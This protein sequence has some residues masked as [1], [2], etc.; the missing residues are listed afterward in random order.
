M[1]PNTVLPMFV[2]FC[3]FSGTHMGQDADVR[4]V[5]A[6]LHSWY[7][8][9]HVYDF[10]ALEG[11]ATQLPNSPAEAHEKFGSCVACPLNYFRKMPMNR[12]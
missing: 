7:E 1:S 11:Q 9:I 2:C 6:M 12:E 5:E 8:A 3:L 10:D 4:A